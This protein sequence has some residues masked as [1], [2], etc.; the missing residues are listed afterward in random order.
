[1]HS[2]TT[3]AAPRVA[4]QYDVSIII[5]LPKTPFSDQCISVLDA[6]LAS[7]GF[8]VLIGRDILR[9]GLLVYDGYTGL[10]TLSF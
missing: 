4:N 3:G 8:K 10:Y 6:E 2:T 1:M 5:P 7:F 9:H